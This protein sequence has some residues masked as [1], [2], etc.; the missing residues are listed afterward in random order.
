M[1]KPT[2][3]ALGLGLGLACAGWL[4]WVWR[5][6]RPA[7]PGVTSTLAPAPAA[8]DVAP[9]NDAPKAP[10]DARTRDLLAQIQRLVA[11][12]NAR[13]KE[14]ILTFKDDEAL[15]RFRARARQAGLTIVSDL[16]ALRTV[17]ISYDDLKSLQN[18]LLQNAED[19]AAVGAN[20]LVS[21]PRAPA[22]EDRAA[23]DQVPFGNR[24][25]SY[26]GA[27]EA[28]RAGGWGRG[29]T[30]AIL[31]TGVG[32]D[33]T[34]G[35]GRVRYLDIGYGTL[36]G[37]GRE[38]GHGTSVASLAAGLAPDAA[39]VAPGASLLSIRV[40]DATGTSDIF[41]LAQAIVAAVDAGAK[42]VNVSLGGYGTNSTLSGAIGYARE[43]GAVIVAAAGN[44]QAAQLAW[45]AADP[46]VISVG[47]IDA[48]DQQVTFSNSGAGL[49]LTAPGYG[50]QT[51][52]LN[53]QRAY[54]DGTSAS[55]PLVSGAI[56]AVM[57]QNPSLT[58][59]QA[60]DLLLR[61]A[62]D[63]GPPGADPAFGNGI[64]NLAW[65]M[66]VNAPGYIDTAISSHYFNPATN[67]FEVVVQNRSAQAVTGATL[68]VAVTGSVGMSF[69][70]PALSAGQSWVA[71]V[72]ADPIALKNA[73]QL[74]FTTQ[75]VNPAGLNDRVPS[76]N[77]KASVLTTPSP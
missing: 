73:G 3:N 19:Y 67:Q 14:A 54:V 45:P 60:A 53:G 66:N 65:A 6:D 64:L 7:S 55:A 20:Y 32:A 22:K 9:P 76:N 18:D 17:R 4:A 15:R 49:Q 34:F 56:A 23:I 25:L 50:V 29:T 68:N 40:T 72:P 31:D 75:L 27:D 1:K 35:Q 16:G 62:S 63:G 33:P 12:A 47:A 11:R 61:T 48:A 36:P 44:D 38:D 39:G 51:A 21:V 77:R 5:A 74:T 42:I 52:W 13:A 37:A 57:S 2:L 58:P 71:R 70:V 8:T 28:S 24:T 46:R 26:L 30:I 43:R 69:T 59:Q 10:V 41:T